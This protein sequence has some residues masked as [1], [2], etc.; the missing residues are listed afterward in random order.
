MACSIPKVSKTPKTMSQNEKILLYFQ[1]FGVNVLYQTVDGELFV[2]LSDAQAAAFSLLSSTVVTINRPVGVVS[3]TLPRHGKWVF[4]PEGLTEGLMPNNL[5]ANGFGEIGSNINFSKFEPFIS[6]EFA[7]FGTSLTSIGDESF[8]C[9][10]K[11]TLAMDGFVPIN[12]K[13]LY[14]FNCSITTRNTDIGDSG[15]CV[16]EMG[17]Q[18]FDADKNPIVK[19][20]VLANP[21]GNVRLRRALMPGDNFMELTAIPPLNIGNGQ[22]NI[23]FLRHSFQNGKTV[24]FY[25]RNII[26]DAYEPANYLLTTNNKIRVMFKTPYVGSVVE[27]NTRIGNPESM[28][29]Y[30]IKIGGGDLVQGGDNQTQPYRWAFGGREADFGVLNDFQLNKFAKFAK[31]FVKQKSLQNFDLV[32][33]DLNFKIGGFIEDITPILGTTLA[34]EP[35]PVFQASVYPEGSR[36]YCNN[37][38]YESSNGNWGT[39]PFTLA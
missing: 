14:V 1:R 4:V 33:S 27:A 19:G 25:T 16:F 11:A 9:N 12:H 38:W 7:E 36:Y 28:S 24:M 15:N 31:F 10:T 13:E 35:F 23:A 21:V 8:L 34:S 29:P 20:N 37:V 30:S 32:L 26:E 6:N 39:R 3:E 22:R 5:I 18:L 2:E 17:L